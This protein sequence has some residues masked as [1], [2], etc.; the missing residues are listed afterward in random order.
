MIIKCY[1]IFFIS[2]NNYGII[3]I[4]V[5]IARYYYHINMYYLFWY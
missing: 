3:N 5:I 1:F 2:D 4:M